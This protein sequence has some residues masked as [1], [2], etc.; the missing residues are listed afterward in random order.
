MKLISDNLT[1]LLNSQLSHE[2]LNANL[3]LYIAGYLKNKGLNKLAKHF[4]DQHSEETEHSIIIFDLLTDLNADV[5]MNEIDE[6]SIP[7]N[8]ISEIAKLYLDREILT[9]D[10]LNEIKNQ[11]IEE[12]NPVVE[13]RMREMI[14]MQQNE[15]AEATDF[16]DKA[17]LVG[18]DWKFVLLWD[19]GAE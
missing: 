3:Y 5:I 14:K 19:L 11:A 8:N 16:M 18:D 7:I 1:D 2:K 15:Y 12:N 9:T 13:E 4:I 10:S 6:V 17:V